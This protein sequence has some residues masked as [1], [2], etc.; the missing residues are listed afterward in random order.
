MVSS[1]RSSQSTRASGYQNIVVSFKVA[2]IKVAVDILL[3]NTASIREVYIHSDSIAAIM[4]LNSLSVRSK[5][6][7]EYM[8]SIAI[9]LNFFR[10]RFFGR[11]DSVEIPEIAKPISH[12]YILYI[13]TYN[14]IE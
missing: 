5:L 4:A 8:P 3:L 10:F 9:A 11:P 2:A 1:I 7:K 13:N 14:Q 6:V 12:T